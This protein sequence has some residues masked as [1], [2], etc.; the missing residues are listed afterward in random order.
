[1]AMPRTFEARMA[2]QLDR[3]RARVRLL[4][5]ARCGNRRTPPRG[6]SEPSSPDDARRWHAA[7]EH[8][9]GRAR[10]A[11]GTPRVQGWPR[12]MLLRS[13]AAVPGWSRAALLLLPLVMGSALVGGAVSSRQRTHEASE[14]LIRGQVDG[15]VR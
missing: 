6:G 15:F 3:A 12:A 4:Q 2:A 7:C 11:A 13:L 9:V 10:R 8:A 5:H 14:L 1:M